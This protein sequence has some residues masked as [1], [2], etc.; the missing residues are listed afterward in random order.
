M[1]KLIDETVPLS[2]TMPDQIKD[3]R[4][5]GK[6]R[7]RLAASESPEELPKEWKQKKIAKL[8][9]EAKSIYLEE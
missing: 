2:Q 7:C 8:K 9:T 4:K 1:L 6:T 3:L 5:F